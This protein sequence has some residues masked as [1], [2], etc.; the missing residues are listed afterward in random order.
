[1]NDPFDEDVRGRAGFVTTA[2]GLRVPVAAPASISAWR[3]EDADAAG[4]R[5]PG[6]AKFRGV[7]PKGY[8]RSDAR[9]HEQVCERLLLDPYLDA[10]GVT[11]RV[12]K[13]RVQLSGTV[14]TERM[15]SAA[16][17]AATSVAAK[18][19]DD[20]ITVDAA[21]PGLPSGKKRARTMSSKRA[22]K[23]RRRGG[24]R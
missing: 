9:L 21:V 2:A 10:S 16:V 7:G 24:S 19:V 6:E 13:G 20:R 1:M 22:V 8:Q 15:R 17:A 18:G 5:M 12:A 11:V 14:R 23:G 3:L 4:A